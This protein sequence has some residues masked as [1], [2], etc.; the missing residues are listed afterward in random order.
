VWFFRRLY[1]KLDRILMALERIEHR[2]V[3]FMA[4]IQEQLAEVIKDMTETKTSIDGM[5]AFIAGL[6]QMLADALKNVITPEIQAQLDVVFA[7]AE[8]NRAAIVAAQEANV[9]PVEPPVEP[10]A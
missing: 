6:K 5:S 7:K 8:E 9:P 2:E 10:P 4:T 3:H 1:N